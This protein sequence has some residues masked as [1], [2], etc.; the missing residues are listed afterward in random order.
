VLFIA[1]WSFLKLNNRVFCIWAFLVLLWAWNNL[2][3]VLSQNQTQ[4]EKSKVF[5]IINLLGEEPSL[6]QIQTFVLNYSAIPSSSEFRNLRKRSRIRNILP[7]LDL[8]AGYDRGVDRNNNYDS[9]SGSKRTPPG[10]SSS[11]TY[12]HSYFDQDLDYARFSD[13]RVELQISS[14]WSLNRLIYDDE[15]TDLISEQRRFA[16]I[17]NDLLK[18]LQALFYDRQKKIISV[19]INP[20]ENLQDKVISLVE[21]RELTDKLDSLSGGWYKKQSLVDPEILIDFN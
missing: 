21:I 13:R 5:R 17:R 19:I 10:I 15:E 20:P 3:F 18:D 12:N 6:V 11:A 2:D 14:N 16:F 4:T 1:F 7:D 8:N 9:N